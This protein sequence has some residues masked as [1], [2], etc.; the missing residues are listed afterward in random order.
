MVKNYLLV[1][2]SLMALLAVGTRPLL[3]SVHAQ[4]KETTVSTSGSPI[5]FEVRNRGVLT[6]I[7][8]AEGGIDSATKVLHHVTIFMF[9]AG[10]A[11]TIIQADS[12]QVEHQGQDIKWELR[13][14]HSNTL[15][16]KFFQVQGASMSMRGPETAMQLQSPTSTDAIHL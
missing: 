14:F 13:Q 8:H 5:T 12:M 9:D 2:I 3:Q 16:P 6:S 11:N 15:Y 10:R 7:I 4:Q 1:T